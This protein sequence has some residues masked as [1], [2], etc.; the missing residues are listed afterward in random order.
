M[1]PLEGWARPLVSE[2]V[3]LWHLLDRRAEHVDD[4]VHIMHVPWNLL[5]QVE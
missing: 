3:R 4:P 2:P 1:H 5:G